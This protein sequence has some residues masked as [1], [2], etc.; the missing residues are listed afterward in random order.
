MSTSPVPAPPPALP[1]A[2]FAPRPRT[3]LLPRPWPALP[4]PC[5]A[6]PAYADKKPKPAQLRISGYGLLGNRRLSTLI[7]TLQGDA[8]KRQTF[9]ANFIEDT[10]LI[11]LSR[12]KD[13]G[14]LEPTLEIQM[15]L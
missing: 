2:L 9:D 12:V 11:L 14:F 1:A 13:D 7:K 3:P 6:P 10:A 4:I 15:T 5:L 8:L